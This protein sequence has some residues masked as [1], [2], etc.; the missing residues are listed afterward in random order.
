MKGWGYDLRDGSFARADKNIRVRL[1]PK[2]HAKPNHII[3]YDADG[4]RYHVQKR[5][6]AELDTIE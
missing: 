4:T 1:A 3:A 2:E 6:L 5:S